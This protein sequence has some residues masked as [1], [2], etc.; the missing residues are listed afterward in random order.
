MTFTAQP[1]TCPPEVTLDVASLAAS[2]YDRLRN[3]IL[4][5]VSNESDADDLVQITYL[6]AF[7]S[8][9]KFRGQSRPETWLFGIA[10]RV[11]AHHYSCSP[12]RKYTFVDVDSVEDDLYVDAPSMDSQLYTRQQLARISASMKAMS[13]SIR[14]T[15]VY[16]VLE[17]ES[18]EST[19]EKFCIPVGTVRSRISRAR[20]ILKKCTADHPRI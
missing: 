18:Y 2:H 12:N 20:S 8:Q 3:F 17:D 19:A 7:R 15:L 4:R 1:T 10:L 13:P 6:E 5:R 11:V 9:S 14:D 16:N